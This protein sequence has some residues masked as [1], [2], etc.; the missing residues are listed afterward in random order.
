MKL[1]MKKIER[2]AAANFHSTTLQA[3][4]EEMA[5]DVSMKKPHCRLLIVEWKKRFRLGV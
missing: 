5:A 4:L 1:S 3:D 2:M